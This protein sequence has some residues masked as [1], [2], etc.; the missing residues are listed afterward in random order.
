MTERLVLGNTGS[1][2]REDLPCLLNKP[3]EKVF[4]TFLNLLGWE[5]LECII[6]TVLQSDVYLR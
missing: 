2:R 5:I 1:L 4:T 6:L 3:M